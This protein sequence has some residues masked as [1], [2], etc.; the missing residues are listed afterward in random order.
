[1]AVPNVNGINSTTGTSSASAKGR[2]FPDDATLKRVANLMGISV[3]DLKA[4]LKKSPTAQ[5]K[6]IYNLAKTVNQM[7]MKH[8]CILNGIDPMDWQSHIVKKG[9]QFYVINNPAQYVGN[10]ATPKSASTPASAGKPADTSKPTTAPKTGVKPDTTTTKKDSVGKSTPEEARDSAKTSST[11][12]IDNRKQ[13]SSDFTP[14]E[15]G[16]KIYEFADNNSKSVGRP[17]F[18]ALI[19]QINSDNVIDVLLKYNDNP[20]NKKESLINTIVSETGSK[21]EDR[22]AAVMHIYD[23]LA[24]AS[25]APKENRAKFEKELNARFEESGFVDTERMEDMLLRMIATPEIIASQIEKEVDQNRGAVGQDSF[26]ELINLIDKDNVAQVMAEYEKLNT[27]ESIFEAIADEVSS[28]AADRQ[29]AIAHIFDAYADSLNTP[30]KVRALFKAELKEQ[31]DSV[32]PMDTDNL[33]KYVELMSAT[34]TEIA[35]RMEEMIDDNFTKGAV[36]EREFQVLLNLVTPKN[37]LE[38]VLRYESLGKETLIEA[39]TSES[40]D[41][42]Q[43]RKDAVMHIYDALSA[44]TFGTEAYREEFVAELDSQ[45]DKWGF[46]KTDKLDEMINRLIDGEGDDIQTRYNPTYAEGIQMGGGSTAQEKAKQLTKDA[47]QAREKSFYQ[48]VTDRYNQYHPSFRETLISRVE[49]D[50]SLSEVDRRIELAKAKWAT[51]DVSTITRPTP[52]LD[53]RGNIITTPEVKELAPYGKSNGKCVIVNIGHGGFS[54]AAFD[55]GAFSYVPKNDGSNEYYAIEE[56]DIA[57]DYS[58][59]LIGKLRA[60][61]YTVVQ[62]SGRVDEMFKSKNKTIETLTNK[63]K[64][65]FGSNKT[66]FISMHC[67]SSVDPA[68]TGSQ[69]LYGAKDSK[70]KVLADSLYRSLGKKDMIEMRDTTAITKDVYV[71]NAS[72]GIPSVLLEI[73]YMTGPDSGKLIDSNYQNQFVTATFSSIEEYFKQAK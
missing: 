37:A 31:T 15:L 59:D 60:Q 35:T 53:A 36:D 41:D 5:G 14:E 25:G 67:N 46:V 13:W 43:V 66:M 22:K 1:M 70:D 12:A 54:N 32:M 65:R 9:E 62:V 7:E 45:F 4:N 26:D 27:G 23:A 47:R 20:N 16:R 61:G 19:E 73:D 55:K 63:Y 69:V 21:E 51:V 52:K 38:V 58:D 2:Q 64:T 50:S 6:G 44:Q 68:T 17:D 10:T 33:E 72:L 56:Y 49:Q 8:F 40:G 3:E 24:E 48:G 34:P 71:L 30:E 39:I 42:A 28:E 18:D 57:K 11:S 29:Q